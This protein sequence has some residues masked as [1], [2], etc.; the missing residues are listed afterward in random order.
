MDLF[1]IKET[2][3]TFQVLT[4]TREHQTPKAAERYQAF[5]VPHKRVTLRYGDYCGMVTLQGGD[6]YDISAAISPCCVI[7]RKMSLDEAATCFTR[8]RARF[9]REFTRA[10][11]AGAKIYLL[12]ENGSWEAIINH[13]YRSR[14]TP[15]AFMASLTAWTVRYDITPIFCKAQTSG[16]LIKEILYRDMKER[17]ERGEYG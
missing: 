7:E 12:I 8:G 14:F 15:Q 4:D 17:L 13:R 1:E 9:E 3:S 10:R 5:G 6:L 16:K 2:L 11:D